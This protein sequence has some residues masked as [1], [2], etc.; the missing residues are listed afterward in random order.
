L[1]TVLLKPGRR[2]KNQKLIEDVIPTNMLNFPDDVKIH[3]ARE[4][5]LEFGTIVSHQ[6]A[7]RDGT[8]AFFMGEGPIIASVQLP[9]SSVQPPE[10][11]IRGAASC[12]FFIQGQ[13]EYFWVFERLED[14]RNGMQVKWMRGY[15]R[16]GETN[17][18]PTLC[19]MVEMGK[20]QALYSVNGIVG[21]TFVLHAQSCYKGDLYKSGKHV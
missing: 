12:Q 4:E 13:G 1:A 3:L 6:N 15:T 7:P 8:D 21:V 11:S 19:D 2:A 17:F 14:G 10:A 18:R 5:V 9:A 20:E 16:L